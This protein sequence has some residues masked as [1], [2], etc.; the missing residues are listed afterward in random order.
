MSFLGPD[1]DQS[2]LIRK[3]CMKAGLK[4]ERRRSLDLGVEIL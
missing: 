2:P 3:E 4:E 1:S